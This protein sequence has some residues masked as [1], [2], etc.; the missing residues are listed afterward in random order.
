MDV[1]IWNYMFYYMLPNPLHAPELESITC[2]RIH[3]MLP[4]S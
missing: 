1:I 2:S 4:N 3:Y